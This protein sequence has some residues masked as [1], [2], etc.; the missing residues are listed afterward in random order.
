MGCYRKKNPGKVSVYVKVPKKYCVYCFYSKNLYVSTTYENHQTQSR[1]CLIAF[2]HY[3]VEDLTPP[4]MTL[5][6]PWPPKEELSSPNGRNH[7]RN[8]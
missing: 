8:V 7:W 4:M 6:L 2:N 3:P 1:L 5:T